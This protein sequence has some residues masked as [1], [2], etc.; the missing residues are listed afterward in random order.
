VAGKFIIGF[1]GMMVKFFIFSFLL[2]DAFTLAANFAL[3]H[4]QKAWTIGVY[5]LG[6]LI[7]AAG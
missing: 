3:V 1:K 7:F 2:V 5:L 4:A 6:S